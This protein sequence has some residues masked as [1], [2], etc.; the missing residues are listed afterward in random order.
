VEEINMVKALAHL[1]FI[2]KD[3]DVAEAFYRDML[4][5][6]PAFD[7]INDDGKRFGTYMHIG[8]RSFLEM[9]IGDVAEP[10]PGQ[11][12]QHLCLEVEDVAAAVAE[13]RGKGAEVTDPFFGSDGSWQAWIS[14]P[15]GNRIELHSYT[16]E[17][18]QNV[19]LE[20]K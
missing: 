4:G 11:S 8:G 6:T 10:A 20:M 7:F 2:V 16:P 13:L 12:F 18:K 17:S 3:L 9:F 14:D 19:A 15:E 5:L 1:C